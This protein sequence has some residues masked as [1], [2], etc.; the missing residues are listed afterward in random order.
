MKPFRHVA[1]ALG[2]LVPFA[3][4]YAC[5]DDE[6]GASTLTPDASVAFVPEDG[7]SGSPSDAS[8]D[9]GTDTGTDASGDAAPDSGEL[10]DA[11]TTDAAAP[12]C[13]IAFDATATA[14]I[15]VTADDYLKLWI[16]GVLVDDKTTTW[17]TVDTKTVTLF[18][19]PTR[20]NV[21]AIEAQ[22]ALNAGGFDRGLLVDMA[23]IDVDAGVDAGPDGGTSGIVSD[24]SWKII[25]S[26]TDG[27]LP[28][29]GLPDGGAPNTPAWFEPTFDDAAWLGAVDEGPHGMSP[30]GAVF[31]TSDARWLWSYDSSAAVN[32]LAP[33][34]V[35][36][37][38]VFYLDTAGNPSDTPLTC[39]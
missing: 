38:K 27:G 15:K 25:G 24:L 30:W 19:H 6:G 1:L 4:L 39:P 13:S 32:K 14:Q 35:Y 7:G 37:R 9:A 31:G 16:N 12:G 17:G 33:E 20:M 34:T 11:S 21:I 36:F 23:G 5:Q 8:S 18:R 10:A 3:F 22:N 29:G 2:A 28:D 26:S